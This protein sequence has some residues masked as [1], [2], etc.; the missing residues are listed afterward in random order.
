MAGSYLP[1]NPTVSHLINSCLFSFF[2][3]PQLMQGMMTAFVLLA[4]SGGIYVASIQTVG[5]LLYG[6]RELTAGVRELTD[7]EHGT[8]DLTSSFITSYLGGFGVAVCASE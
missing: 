8:G 2:N 3:R 6:D 5:E 7:V 4:T 1:S